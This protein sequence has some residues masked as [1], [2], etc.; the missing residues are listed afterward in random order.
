MPG[1]IPGI[2]GGIISGF[3]VNS[4]TALGPSTAV[5]VLRFG[6]VTLSAAG[7]GTRYVSNTQLKVQAAPCWTV[8]DEVKIVFGGDADPGPTN[9]TATL[10]ISKNIGPVVLGGQNSSL[11]MHLW[12][13]SNATTA[14]SW[15]LEMAWWER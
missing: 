5:T 13:P 2:P 1:I 15:A 14:P 8:G 10:A 7:G 4:N 3:I 11:L 6:A 12:N 9:G